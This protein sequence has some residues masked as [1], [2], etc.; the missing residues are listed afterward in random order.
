MLNHRSEVVRDKIPTT[1]YFSPFHEVE[2]KNSLS[3]FSIEETKF[4]ESHVMSM[5]DDLF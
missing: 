3:E 1:S 4:T 5:P 2:S